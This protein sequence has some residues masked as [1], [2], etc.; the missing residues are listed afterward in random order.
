MNSSFG[1]EILDVERIFRFTEY[2]DADKVAYFIEVD[3]TAGAEELYSSTA[4]A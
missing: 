2:T 3:L 1:R 4:E